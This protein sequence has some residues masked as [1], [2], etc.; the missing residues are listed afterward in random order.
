MAD[1]F[2][3]LPEELEV[4]DENWE[5]D[6]RCIKIK[7]RLGEGAFGQV[8][9][10]VLYS[11]LNKPQQRGVAVKMLKGNIVQAQTVLI[12][13]KILTIIIRLLR[14]TGLITAGLTLS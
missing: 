1:S 2:L 11:L 12:T 14:E 6:R 10:G 5:I 3:D 7:E 9:K 4:I 8:M 13:C